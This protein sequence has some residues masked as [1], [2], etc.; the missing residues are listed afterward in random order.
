MESN[1]S[2]QNMMHIVENGFVNKISLLYTIK[3]DVCDEYNVYDLDIPYNGIEPGFIPYEDLTEQQ[4][5]SWCFDS[6]KPGE[7]EAIEDETLISFQKLESWTQNQLDK[8]G[9]IPWQS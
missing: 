5:L 4:V 7:K 1:W 3:G 2:V 9:G 8:K 6:M